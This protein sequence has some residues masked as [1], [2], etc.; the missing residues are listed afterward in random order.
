MSSSELFLSGTVGSRLLHEKRETENRLGGGGGG[1]GG[2][3]HLCKITL[4]HFCWG[5]KF[6]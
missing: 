3:L 6:V 4:L 5:K 2:V 1:G